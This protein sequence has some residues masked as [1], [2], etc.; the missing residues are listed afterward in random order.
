MNLSPMQRQ[1]IWV[2]NV[3]IKMFET[4]KKLHLYFLILRRWLS[5][6]VEWRTVQVFASIVGGLKRGL[7]GTIDLNKE[8]FKV[9]LK[10]FTY[11]CD[12]QTYFIRNPRLCNVTDL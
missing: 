12:I 4:L 8:E 1:Y 3:K 6:T 9:S 10:I 2:K 5:A 11:W 7:R